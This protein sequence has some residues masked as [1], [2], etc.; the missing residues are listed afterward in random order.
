MAAVQPKPKCTIEELWELSHRTGKRLELVEGEL[1]QLAPAS[2]EHGYITNQ[3]A[4]LV[5]RFVKEHR[6]GY[7]L[8]AET[9]FVL[10]EEPATVRAPDLAYVSRERAP[11]Q[12]SRHFAR[13]VPDLVA[14]VVSPADT[15]SEV[16]RKVQ[17]WLT[18]GVKLVWVVDPESRQVSV[19]RAGQPVHILS[20]GDTLS[21]EEV[22]PGFACKVSEIFTL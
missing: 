8:A 6:L 19:H 18:A 3:I 9:G 2:D 7:T 16:V 4:F 20:E 15:Y 12:W 1:R 17:D 22:L 13:F 21:G 11:Q 10:H 14:E 5:T